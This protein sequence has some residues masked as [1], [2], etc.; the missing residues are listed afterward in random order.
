RLSSSSGEIEHLVLLNL[1]E[2][3]NALIQIGPIFKKLNF[4]L[5]TKDN[6][7]KL[8]EKLKIA[9]GWYSSSLK[10][11]NHRESF[12]FCAIG[13]EALLTNG[14]DSITKTLSENTA[15]LIASRDKD[16]RKYIYT[17]LLHKPICKGFFSDIIFK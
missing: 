8:I 17:A 1:K 7:N 3:T 10:T 2:E 4:P 16:S 15:F 5:Y 9:I 13:M 11:L 14:R 6:N 12:L